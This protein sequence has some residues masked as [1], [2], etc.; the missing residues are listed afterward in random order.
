[1]FDWINK[2][3][4]FDTACKGFFNYANQVACILVLL[5]ITNVYNFFKNQTKN[6]TYVILLSLAMIT[7]GTRISTLG[8]LLVLIC[9]CLLTE[10]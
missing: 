9:I 8:G 4:Y 3:Y 1:M 6:I 10:I 2:P 5:L 7:L